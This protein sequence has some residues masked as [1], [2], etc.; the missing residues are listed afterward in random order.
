MGTSDG[1]KWTNLFQETD[2][3]KQVLFNMEFTAGIEAKYS[4][5]TFR[6]VSFSGGYGSP[7]YKDPYT[8]DKDAME[9][10]I[11]SDFT[12]MLVVNKLNGASTG[13]TVMEI[14]ESSNDPKFIKVLLNGLNFQGSDCV[15]L[16]LKPSPKSY[17]GFIRDTATPLKQKLLIF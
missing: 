11:S 6:Y 12:K 14:G 1:I 9:A 5:K 10:C 8:H 17:Y 13:V 15:T 3:T 7:V 2:A 4:T 16:V